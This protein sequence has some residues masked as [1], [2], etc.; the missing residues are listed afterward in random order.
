M[1]EDKQERAM[2]VCPVCWQE[3]SKIY[4]FRDGGDVIG[5]DECIEE[6]DAE[7]YF[8]MEDDE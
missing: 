1:F 7:E 5:C 4:R 2:P 8:A 6:V 3:C